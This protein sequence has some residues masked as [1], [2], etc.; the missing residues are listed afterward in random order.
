MKQVL[1]ILFFA[2][3]SASA[4]AQSLTIN[5]NG[6]LIM[7]GNVSLVVRNAALINNGT[8]V[9]SAG[10]VQFSG[11]KDTSFSY[12][13]GTRPTSVYNLSINKEGFGTALKS[14]VAVQN[15]LGVY[16]GILYP[17]SNLTLRS[18]KEL[19][20]RVDVIPGGADIIGK[21]IV[22]RYFPKRRAWRLVTSPL[23]STPS[24]FETWQN[25]GIY[26]PGI[27]T[28]VTGPGA[29]GIGG[30]GLDIS[31]QNNTSMKIW[32]VNTQA[33]DPITNTK[34]Q[35]SPANGSDA[36]NVGYFLFVRGDRDP[37]NFN[38]P[39]CNST[40]LSSNGRLQ[41]GTQHLTASA[42]A[43]GYTLMGNPFASPI[44]FNDVVRTNL[45]KR[46]YVWDPNLNVLGGYVML[47]DLDNDGNYTKS[48][49]ASSQTKHIQSSQAF[50]VET[51]TNGTAGIN[52]PESCK[53]AGNNNAMFRP[54]T[55]DATGTQSIRVVLNLKENDGS[56]IVADGVLLE[57]NDN[58]SDSINRDDALKFSNI[59]ETFSIV[60]HNYP[61]AAERRPSL[62]V[63]DT[64]F[65][66]LQK[67]TQRKYAFQIE[68]A[69][70]NDPLLTAWLEDSYL[71]T[72]VAVDLYN[73]SLFE[74]SI[75]ANAAS[76]AGNRFRIVFKQV[77][78]LP[79][80]IVS[81]NAVLQ[82]KAVAVN[83]I[84]ENEINIAKYEVERSPDAI[85]FSSIAEKETGSGGTALYTYSISDNDPL[86][87]YNYYRI[88]YTDET[89]SVHYSI[90]VKVKYDGTAHPVIAVYP[91]PIENNI[92]NLQFTNCKEGKYKAR[93][94]SGSGQLTYET[95]ITVND[96]NSKVVITPPV[97]LAAGTYLLELSNA[98]STITQKIMVK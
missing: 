40:T 21:S 87:G 29:N 74:F 22:E 79:V 11:G 86:K 71:N 38:I 24:I 13:G 67:A 32:N 55:N 91:N 72:S 73:T 48:I 10:T 75:D 52:F 25:K 95:N 39:N 37:D 62:T 36:D 61:L 54:G 4:T 33:L 50:F 3:I 9:D 98:A 23:N 60:R 47:D 82:D 14:K 26:E 1:H 89:G 31:P 96:G 46:F 84:V 5:G 88:K 80:T 64:I 83:W 7:K 20:A 6:K 90:I 12:L 16:D 27:N 51:Q 45:V 41:T 94:M 77:A 42:V 49:N 85:H 18:D 97:H 76:A 53:S 57:C 43:G 65:F 19:T 59:N 30:N 58:F 93:L 92:I 63:N 66:K 17:D 34:E 81:V 35:L 28:F 44:D 15:V 2:F 56:L 8:L 68:P 69:A 78:L 70:I